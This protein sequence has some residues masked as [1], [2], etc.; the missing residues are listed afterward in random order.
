MMITENTE[1][2][3][4]KKSRKS[5]KNYQTL[6]RT[7]IRHLLMKT[8]ICLNNALKPLRDVILIAATSN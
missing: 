4:F 8:G 3:T 7:G 6:N 5:T 2:L 1:S